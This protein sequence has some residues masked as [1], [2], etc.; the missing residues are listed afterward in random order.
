MADR[1]NTAPTAAHARNPAHPALEVP[2]VIAGSVNLMQ[3]SEALAI[4]GIVGRYDPKRHV[5]VIEPAGRHA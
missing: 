2:A 5:L 4:A 1:E 3:F